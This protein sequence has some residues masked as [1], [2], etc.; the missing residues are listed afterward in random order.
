MSGKIY[1]KNTMKEEKKTKSKKK[2]EN[3]VKTLLK[4]KKKIT[5]IVNLIKAFLKNKSRSY[6][7]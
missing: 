6:N 4:Q 1:A 7:H 3:G 5:I 2:L